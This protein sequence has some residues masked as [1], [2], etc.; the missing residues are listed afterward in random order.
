MTDADKRFCERTDQRSSNWVAMQLR[1]HTFVQPD[2]R[3]GWNR[4]SFTRTAISRQYNQVVQ[5]VTIDR[6]T[7]HVAAYVKPFKD[8][9]RTSRSRLHFASLHLPSRLLQEL[10]VRCRRHRQNTLWLARLPLRL[11]RLTSKSVC[12]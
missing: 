5:M 9:F 8:R 7:P 6:V 12:S 11:R 10:D 4:F 2:R 3:E 1:G